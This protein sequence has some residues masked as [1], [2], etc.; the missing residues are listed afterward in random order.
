M[1]LFIEYV[2]IFDYCYTVFF[3]FIYIIAV[4]IGQSGWNLIT[5]KVP[6][7]YVKELFIVV[8]VYM[9]FCGRVPYPCHPLTQ[10]PRPF[11]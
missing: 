1:L 10:T 6:W 4:V 8:S 2:W 3:G 5:I 9:P 11:N 7:C